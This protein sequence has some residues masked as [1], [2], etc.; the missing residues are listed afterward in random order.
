MTPTEA[1]KLLRDA[2]QAAES[3]PPETTIISVDVC[4]GP[5]EPTVAI[6]V[7]DLPPGMGPVTVRTTEDCGNGPLTFRS[8][9]LGEVK[10]FSVE[11]GK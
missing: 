11:I 3:L 5:K 1:V 8:V 10:A 4:V 7:R 9:W 6:H 2:I